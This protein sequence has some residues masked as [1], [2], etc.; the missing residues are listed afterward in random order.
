[1]KHII[2][3]GDGMADH[4]VERLGGKTPLQYADTPYMDMLARQGRCGRLITVPDGFLP[5]SEVANSSILGYDQHK[6]YEGRGPLE[7]AGIGYNLQQG[8]LAMRC[9]IISMEGGRIKNHHGGHLATDEGRRLTDWL[10]EKLGGADVH[11]VKGIQYRHLLI[12]KGGNKHVECAPPH[13]H[14]NDEWKKLKARAETGYDFEAD[15]EGKYYTDAEGRRYKRKSPQE[16][17]DLI[18]RLTE[19]SQQLL[20]G[21][22]LNGER[23]ARGED[24][25][26][27]IWPWGGGYRPSMQTMGEMYPQIRR[28]AVIT[29]VDL[30]RGIGRYAGLRNIIV[31]GATGLAD[32]DYEGKAQAAIEALRTDDFVFLHVD[33]SDEAGHD[34]DLRLKIKTIEDFDRRIVGPIYNEV[35]TWAEPVSIAVMPDHPTPVEIRTH[36]NDPVPFLIHYPGIEP[37]GVQTYDE[38]SCMGGSYG[39]LRPGQFMETFME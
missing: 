5:G 17:A 31:E 14:L 16:T 30:I 27:S 13:D 21:H 9:N 22:P 35:K 2:I 23:R 19:E 8:D 38:Q 37:D 3:L 32:T 34:G 36:V 1:M 6:V 18:N 39:L 33:A 26:N 10:E 4:R 11:F 20:A 7:A 15:A 28:G 25:A 29:A 12:I 24:M